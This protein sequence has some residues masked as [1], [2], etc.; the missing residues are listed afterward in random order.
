VGSTPT[1]EASF[2]MRR[3]A[4]AKTNGSALEFYV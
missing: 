1:S 3:I 2:K 4:G